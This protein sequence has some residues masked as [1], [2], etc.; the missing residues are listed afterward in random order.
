MNQYGHHCTESLLRPH[1]SMTWRR[2]SLQRSPSPAT[3]TYDARVALGGLG[4]VVDDSSW[5]DD[6]RCA[7]G[8]LPHLSAQAISLVEHILR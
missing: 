5:H 4:G 7:T 1:E 2:T 3:Q 8:V 6:R